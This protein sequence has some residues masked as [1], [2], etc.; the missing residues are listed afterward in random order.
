MIIS[1][2][3]CVY[4]YISCSGRFGQTLGS[5]G[6]PFSLEAI[7]FLE[8]PGVE[9][10]AEVKVFGSGWGTGNANLCHLSWSFIVFGVFWS[11]LLI[12]FLKFECLD[13]IGFLQTHVWTNLLNLGVSVANTSLDIGFLVSSWDWI[14]W[15]GFRK[16]Q[17]LKEN[18]MSSKQRRKISGFLQQW[19]LF[20]GDCIAVV[21][22]I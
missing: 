9:S 11:I 22:G 1:V 18:N 17:G 3:N 6:A 5:H 14:G 21:W 15:I 4:I 10:S 16:C 2:Y 19:W 12:N 13:G 7:V 8:E 20:L